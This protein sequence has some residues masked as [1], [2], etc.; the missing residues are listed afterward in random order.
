VSRAGQ[1]LSL[2]ASLGEGLSMRSTLR[3]TWVMM[4]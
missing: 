1:A 2:G 4:C 3:V